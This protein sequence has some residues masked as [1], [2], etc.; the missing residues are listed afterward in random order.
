MFP[1]YLVEYQNIKM[2]SKFKSEK[3]KTKKKK[4]KSNV[5][6]KENSLSAFNLTFKQT[7][8]QLTM[9]QSNV[10]N[11]SHILRWVLSKM[12]KMKA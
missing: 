2:K 11:W 10:E 8:K 1:K 6:L 7:I 12:K 9:K 5:V 4:H 3:S